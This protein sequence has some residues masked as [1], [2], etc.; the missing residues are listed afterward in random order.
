MAHWKN[1]AIPHPVLKIS[2]WYR[3]LGTIWKNGLAP[4]SN[5]SLTSVVECGALLMTP[6]Q[7]GWTV[8]SFRLLTWRIFF[9]SYIVDSW[10]VGH[11]TY[12]AVWLG[13]TRYFVYFFSC[14]FS[15]CDCYYRNNLLPAVFGHLRIKQINFHTLS[16]WLQR[17]PR[18][19]INLCHRVIPTSTQF[20][21]GR[22]DQSLG[23]DL[24]FGF[25]V[26]FGLLGF[27]DCCAILFV[28]V[29][30]HRVQHQIFFLTHSQS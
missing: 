18:D 29:V 6:V 25:C 30:L 4:R 23:H 21:F 22:F 1:R 27:P 2:E 20:F 12:I 9:Y 13:E 15:N 19:S 16:F 24:L 11:I 17:L 3:L 28:T 26:S 14:S 7:R 8:L 5:L 10:S